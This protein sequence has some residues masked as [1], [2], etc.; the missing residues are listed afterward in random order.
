MWWI[1]LRS[2]ERDVEWEGI[3]REIIVGNT[4]AWL[5]NS[6]I[7]GLSMN[8][9]TISSFSRYDDD[10]NVE[11]LNKAGKINNG[12]GEGNR[13]ENAKKYL[14]FQS[15][16][17]RRVAFCVFFKSTFRQIYLSFSREFSYVHVYIYRLCETSKTESEIQKK[18]KKKT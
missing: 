2:Q 9:D 14:K 12:N 7:L 13:K 8:L 11:S 6:I 15:F 10:I 3:T 1:L 4:S 18:N 17:E 16:A 5:P